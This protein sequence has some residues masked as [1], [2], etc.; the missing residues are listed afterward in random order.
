MNQEIPTARVGVGAM[1]F[2]DGKVLLGKRKGSHGAGEYAW[3]GGHLEFGEKLEECVVREVK[4]ET[5]MN[6][7]A[8]RPLAISNVIKYGKHY[9]DIQFLV[10][11]ISGHPEVLEPDRVE[12]WNW[13]DIDE[14]P[15]PMFEMSK[16]GLAGFKN[17]LGISY[18]SE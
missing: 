14:L 12:S 6:V 5:G 11:Y 17:D 10:E 9:L 13:Y 16:R 1:V 8:V 3:P 4:E 15:E 2:K 7:R 18:F